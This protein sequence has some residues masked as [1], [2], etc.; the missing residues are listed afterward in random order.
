MKHLIVLPGNNISNESWGNRMLS[1][2]SEY[3]DS[4]YLAEYEHWKT[5]GETIN[6]AVEEERLREHIATLP[7][8]TAVF[9]LAKSAGSILTFLA[10]Q[11]GV[12]NPSYCAFFGLPLDWAATDVFSGNWSVL[13]PFAVPSIAFHNEHDPIAEYTFTKK[14]VELY[15]PRISFITTAGEDHLY[16]DYEIYDQYLLTVFKRETPFVRRNI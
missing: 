14:I 3:F 10:V 1:H 8:D 11:S 12:L 9:V 13:K 4:L 5:G 15:L 7:K 6:L 16:D 2:Y